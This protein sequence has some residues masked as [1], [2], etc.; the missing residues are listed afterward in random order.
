MMNPSD[1]GM[2]SQMNVGSGTIIAQDRKRAR[3]MYKRTRRTMA[4]FWS[5]RD[6]QPSFPVVTKFVNTTCNRK[7]VLTHNTADYADCTE[8]WDGSAETK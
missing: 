7:A 4:E 6:F 8:M 5:V 2:F 1:I 3:E